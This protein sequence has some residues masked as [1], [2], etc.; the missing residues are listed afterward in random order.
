MK[1][2]ESLSLKKKKGKIGEEGVGHELI[3]EGQMDGH[4]TRRKRGKHN[5]SVTS[6]KYG[7]RKTTKDGGEVNMKVVGSMTAQEAR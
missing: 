1:I 4:K 7:T 6:I 3:Y 2:E 5:E